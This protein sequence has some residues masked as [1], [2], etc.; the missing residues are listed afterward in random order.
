MIKLDDYDDCD[1]EVIFKILN[2]DDY[3]KYDHIICDQDREISA[4]FI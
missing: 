2:I 3:Y 1:V 4:V